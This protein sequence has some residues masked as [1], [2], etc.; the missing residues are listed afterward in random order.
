MSLSPFIVASLVL[1]VVVLVAVVAGLA[2]NAR[3]TLEAYGPQTP[4]RGIL[5]S[6][7]VAIGVA[8][9]VLLVRADAA[10]AIALLGVQVLYKVTTPFTVSPRNP[11]VISNLGIAAW[12]TVALVLSELARRGASE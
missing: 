1:N 6:V 10:G 3:W 9:V 7:Y 4:A 12:H 8:S 11:V 2:A 5:T